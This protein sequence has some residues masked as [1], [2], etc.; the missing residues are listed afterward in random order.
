M[1]RW[2]ILGHEPKIVCDTAHNTEGL[3]LV[4][5]QIRRENYDMLHIVLG[6]VK[7][8][9]LRAILS[10]F[11]K[12]AKYYYCTPTIQR[13]LAVEILHSSALEFGLRGDVYS[14][15]AKALKAAK[16]TA[17]R[18]DFIFVGGSNFV[19]AEVV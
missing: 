18:N 14:S 19:V 6:F 4:L 13:G 17:S 7:D 16:K 10:L 11:P 8:K 12:N 1:G 5:E 3:T 15:V 9:N 2:Q